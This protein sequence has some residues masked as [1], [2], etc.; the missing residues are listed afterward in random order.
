MCLRFYIQTS[1][2]VST[3]KPT[4]SLYT[5]KPMQYLTLSKLQAGLGHSQ[6]LVCFF[7]VVKS[8]FIQE[9][10]C[11][12][13]Y[14]LSSDQDNHIECTVLK[15]LNALPYQCAIKHYISKVLKLWWIIINIWPVVTMYVHITSYISYII[16]IAVDFIFLIKVS[17]IFLPQVVAG[18]PIEL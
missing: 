1:R 12:S 17:D 2:S 9:F 10:K 18:G 11:T 14:I 3:P 15:F 13:A 7:L 4:K 6:T 8:D 5:N 16:H